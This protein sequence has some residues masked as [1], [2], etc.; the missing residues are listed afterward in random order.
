MEK[1]ERKFCVFSKAYFRVKIPRRKKKKNDHTTTAATD[2][3]WGRK[4]LTMINWYN[5]ILV[6]LNLKR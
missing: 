3:K 4:K 5:F 6:R 2:G 1:Y